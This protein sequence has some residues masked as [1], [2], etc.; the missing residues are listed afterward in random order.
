MTDIPETIQVVSPQVAAMLCGIPWTTFCRQMKRL[1]WC[2]C[3]SLW[4]SGARF[5][6]PDLEKRLGR[7]ITQAEIWRTQLA[8]RNRKR[9]AHR[10][11]VELAIERQHGE[12]SHALA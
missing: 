7:T 9:V 8:L 6:V 10:R 12:A 3:M 4:P 2:E 5:R 11:H 1:E